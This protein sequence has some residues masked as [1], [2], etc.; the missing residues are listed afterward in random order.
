MFFFDMGIS[1][2]DVTRSHTLQDSSI[3]TQTYYDNDGHNLS[4]YFNSS[5]SQGIGSLPLDA[6]LSFSASKSK[7]KTSLNEQQD[8]INSSNYR[9]SVNIVSRM[10]SLF[11]FEL[12][13]YYSN[14]EYTYKISSFS[15]NMSSKGCNAGL[16]CVYK[17]FRGNIR[18]TFTYLDNETFGRNYNNLGF[19]LEYKI[20]KWR[21]H[22]QGSNIFNI[23]DMDWV[24]ISANELYTSSTV[25]KKI[26]GYILGGITYRF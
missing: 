6:K 3:V 16:I 7:S 10:K 25:Y 8:E 22:I 12:G 17:N 24:S 21:I 20:K 14:S 18:Y 26:P 19:R 5:L 23:A 15:N 2:N 13:G 9:I 4:R 1:D 11:N